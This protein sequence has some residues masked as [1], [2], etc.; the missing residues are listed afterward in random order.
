MS[1]GSTVSSPTGTERRVRARRRMD[2]LAYVDFGPDNGAILIDLSEG[3]LGFHSVAPVTLDQAVLLKFKLPGSAG[4]IESYAEVA[5][6]NETGKGG[7]LRFV[8]MKPELREQIGVWAGTVAATEIAATESSPAEVSNKAQRGTEAT[9]AKRTEAENTRAKDKTAVE[10]AAAPS[11]V[12]LKP[13]PVLEEVP[14]RISEASADVDGAEENRTAALPAVEANQEQAIAAASAATWAGSSEPIQPAEAAEAG[15]KAGEPAGV[16]AART[17]GPSDG[18]SSRV[19]SGIMAASVDDSATP[20]SQAPSP[21]PVA[22]TGG[23]RE[24]QGP[25]SPAA[26]SVSA[27][28]QGRAATQA[29]IALAAAG[30]E[31]GHTAAP[32]SELFARRSTAWKPQNEEPAIEETTASQALKIGIGVAAAVVLVLAIVAVVPSLRT[33]VFATANAKSNS[34][35]MVAG[36]REFQVEVADVNNRRWILKSGGEA[37]SPFADTSSR[38]NAQPAAAPARKNGAKSDP[39]TQSDVASE[40]P[41]PQTPQPKAATPGE[42]VLARPLKGASAAPQ[43]ENLPPSIFDGITPPIGSLVDNLRSAAPN[44]PGPAP[45]QAGARGGDLQAAILMTRVAPVYPSDALKDGVRGEVQVRA[46]ISKDG[47]PT[48]LTVINGDPRLIQAALQAVRQWRYRPA[49]LEGQPIETTT[50]VS[51]SFGFN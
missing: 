39:S 34:L 29:R 11:P 46:T 31:A 32:Q 9:P 15:Q 25:A 41:A 28:S 5:W 3:G 37:G 23:T 38:R 21:R 20:A 43:A 27:Q 24:K 48:K 44:A 47:I 26:N 13:Q 42:L 6:L 40:A 4:F 49:T 1:S 16:K 50:T 51:I 45:V 14:A 12:N 36:I 17:A 19:H 8:E 33:R 2:G 22:T 35:P 7:G 10:A 30:N 18:V